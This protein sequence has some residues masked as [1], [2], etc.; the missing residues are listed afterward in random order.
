MIIKCKMCGGDI[1]FASGATYGV[2]SYCSSTSTIPKS[3]DE[4]K[5]IL[6]NRA[7]HFRR[8]GEFDKAVAAYERLLEQDDTD[9]EAHW[10]AVLS[11]YGIEYVEDPV[12]KKRIPTCHRLQ[13]TSILADEDYKAAVKYAP[14]AE[15]RRLYTEQ[16]TQ[17]A[18]IQKGILT[19]SATEKPYDVFICYKETDEHGRRTHDSQWA[20]EIYYGLTDQGYKVFFSRI[21]LEDKLGQ[22]YEPYIF[23]ALNSARV[24][25][26]VGSK[27]E[28]FNAV[29]VRNEWSRFLTLMKADRSRLLIPCYRGMD[30]YDLPEELSTL[31][32]QDMS[33][34]GFMQDL[35]RG[36]KKVLNAYKTS[37]QPQPLPQAP[38][39]P[40]MPLAAPGITN[41]MKRVHLFLEDGDFKSASDYLNRILDMDPE[42]SAAYAAKLC[43]AFGLHK[44]ADLAKLTF[45][46]EN[47][48]DWKKVVRFAS[49]QQ[50]NVYEDYL[51]QVN[52]RISHQI[53][54]F[55]YD[56]AMEMAVNP[57]ADPEKLR[58]ELNA[59]IDSCNKYDGNKP[60]GSRRPNSEQNEA[61]FEQALQ[62]DNPEKLSSD[63]LTAAASMFESIGDDNAVSRATECRK[64]IDIIN[65]KKTYDAAVSAYNNALNYNKG[66]E[67][68]SAF[69]RTAQ[70]F[71]SISGY[72]DA[73]EMSQRCFG[74]AEDVRCSLYNEA[75]DTMK[76]AGFSSEKW[77]MAKQMLDDS[78]LNNYRDVEQLRTKAAEQYDICS[79]RDRQQKESEQREADNAKRSKKWGLVFFALLII[80]VI[81]IYYNQ[82]VQKTSTGNKS[83][84][85]TVVSRTATP[86][87]TARSSTVKASTAATAAPKDKYSVGT[88]MK[89]GTYVQAKSSVKK[90]PIEWLILKRDGQKVL[91]ISRYALNCKQYNASLESTS[92]ETCSLRKM[93]N[94]DFL[95]SAF[96]SSEQ[97]SILTTTVD[98]S[99]IQNAGRNGGN[100]T[101]DKL[102]LLSYKEAT[103]LFENNEA[104]KCLP[105][106]YS[107]QQGAATYDSMLLNGKPTC[108]WWLRSPGSAPSKAAVI[109]GSE[110]DYEADVTSIYGCVRP[111]MWIDLKSAGFI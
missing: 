27:P 18:V 90:E 96:T 110:A 33:K 94:I 7:N 39:T 46:F 52:T 98:N 104:R 8:Q 58:N 68:I 36:I 75:L 1:E 48:P 63:H 64:L 103:S 82:N 99:S 30:P 35:I 93:L 71:Q 60:N 79:A 92:W 87:T 28:Y 38:R 11:R 9:A 83:P 43:V 88:Y 76:Y 25:V 14:D 102:F 53:N 78:A 3:D 4:S 26:V 32:S 12:T 84:A 51:D 24:M 67:K 16:G 109:Y 55:E 19:I 106:G 97:K 81:I 45:R 70:V 10:G 62:S 29:W 65:K 40:V 56:C 15:S 23:A 95:N 57:N 20:Q 47:H 49:Q 69:E 77:R 5:L 100:N 59:Y 37:E 44:E 6:Y 74:K 22:Q 2:C 105:T 41:L 101:Q 21:T 34:I 50:L 89:F 107:L 42:N 31:Q 73:D 86:K 66:K 54:D 108:W 80:A 91:I 61:L 111:A 13:L 85:A 17:I 72:K